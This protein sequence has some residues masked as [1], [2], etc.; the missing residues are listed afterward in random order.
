MLFCDGK[1]VGLRRAE[2][3]DVVHEEDRPGSLG[4]ES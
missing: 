1:P 2:L 3:P 4:E